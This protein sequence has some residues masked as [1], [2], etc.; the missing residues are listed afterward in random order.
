MIEARQ[1]HEI[2]L[3]RV[4]SRYPQ[5]SF[6]IGLLGEREG[7]KVVFNV[8]GTGSSIYPERSNVPRSQRALIMHTLD[9]IRRKH[10]QLKAPLFLKLDVQGAELDV[11]RG[12]RETLAL[13]EVV[14]LE[15]PLIKYNEGAPDTSTV[16]NYMAAAGYSVLDIAGYVKPDRKSLSHVDLLFV[17]GNS[18]LQPKYFIFND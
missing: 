13:A 1:E 12:G 3:G 10:K 15:V 11:L 14:Q 17:S 2:N 16:V 6:E 5:A 8:M 18:S 9:G 7:S 4:C